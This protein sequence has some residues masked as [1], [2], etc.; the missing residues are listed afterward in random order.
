[1]NTNQQGMAKLFFFMGTAAAIT[2][3]IVAVHLYSSFGY[4]T[5]ERSIYGVIGLILAMASVST[6]TASGVFGTQ[7][8]F[9]LSFFC[10]LAWIISVGFAVLAHVGFM[11]SAMVN[12][13]SHS[14]SAELNRQKIADL[15]GQIEANASILAI[16][17]TALKSQIASKTSDLDDARQALAACP[18][19]YVSVCI[20]PNQ[21]KVG[22]LQKQLTELQT[23]Y[24]EYA[25]VQGLKTLQGDL[26]SNTGVGMKSIHEMQTPVLFVMMSAY[27]K[28]S[29]GELMAWTLLAT[30]IFFEILTSLFFVVYKSLS[31]TKFE[32]ATDN[33]TMPMQTI[34][35]QP[36]QVPV[37]Q[38]PTQQWDYPALGSFVK[39]A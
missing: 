15:S 1:M 28:K 27:F 29:P 21:S 38:L 6:L 35:Q 9:L 3:I 7:A 32:Q 4:S 25:R 23:K 19:T 17:A 24:N 33:R 5:L 2:S 39:K 20:R 37:A 16:D 26:Q 36:T 8:K 12:S 22:T 10:F 30:S 11:S 18:K 34:A 31:D 13:S 14:E